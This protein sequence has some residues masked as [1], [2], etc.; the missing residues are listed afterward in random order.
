MYKIYNGSV[1][2]LPILTPNP[3]TP[4]SHPPRENNDA[5]PYPPPP[6][7][8]H[9]FKKSRAGP[10][11]RRCDTPHCIAG[12]VSTGQSCWGGGEEAVRGFWGP[13]VWAGRS[14][15]CSREALLVLQVKTCLL[16]EKGLRGA[17]GAAAGERLGEVG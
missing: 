4:G 1:L 3:P 13:V 8:M 5:S 9:V 7:N 6:G 14:G 17:A 11:S 16:E 10:K 12:A 2:H 15:P